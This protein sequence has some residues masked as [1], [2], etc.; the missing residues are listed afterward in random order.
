MKIAVSAQGKQITDM[1]DPRFG[2][3]PCFIIF[4][5]DTDQYEVVDNARNAMAGQGAGVQA[6]QNVA[7]HRPDIVVSGNLG[8]KAFQ[9]L[10]SAGIK[11]ALWDKGNVADAIDLVRSNKL[12]FSKSAN[13]AGHWS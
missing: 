8:P 13:V 11:I 3:A 5:T 7:D 6:A 2:R 9:V 12:E 10:S 1:V 4:D